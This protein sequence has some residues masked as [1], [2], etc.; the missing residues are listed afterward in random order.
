VPSRLPRT[1]E[2]HALIKPVSAGQ[3]VTNAGGFVGKPAQRPMA[4]C[5]YRW[6]VQAIGSLVTVLSKTR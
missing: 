2:H 6:P 4:T 1:A 5:G 3:R